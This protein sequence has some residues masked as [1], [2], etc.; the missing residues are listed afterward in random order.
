MTQRHFVP[1]WL[2]TLGLVLASVGLVSQGATGAQTPLAETRQRADEGDVAAQ[3]DLGAAY[4]LGRDVPQD[5]AQ[6]MA[7]YRKAADQGLA[8]AQYNLGFMYRNGEGVPQDDTQAA[9][10]WRKA[11]DQG[12][13]AA[14]FN[15]G[16]MYATGK[17]MPQDYVEAHKW[18]NL[19]ASRVTGDEQ[20][21]YAEA[22]DA[23]A[24]QM[25]PAQLAEAQRLA[26]E[27]QAAFEK[28]QAD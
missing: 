16:G 1:R 22:R 18:Q 17:G 3:Y 19:A 28:R 2:G 5:D 13:A 27:W 15:L 4:E 6:A 20:K 25:T 8:E 11:A 21:E 26:R 23:L 24:K 7:W 14:Q 12:F 10:W 9:A